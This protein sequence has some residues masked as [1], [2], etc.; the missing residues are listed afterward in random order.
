MSG[1]TEKGISFFRLGGRTAIFYEKI[2]SG[3]TIIKNKKPKAIV[4]C[5][6]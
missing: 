1:F 4:S 6:P 5:L 3:K 2:L